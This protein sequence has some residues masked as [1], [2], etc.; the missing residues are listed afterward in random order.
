[1]NELRRKVEIKIG[2][3]EERDRLDQPM[4]AKPSVTS[5]ATYVGSV[6]LA[7]PLSL[8]ISPVGK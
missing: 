2:F 5:D 6:Y 4:A 8:I 3:C 1:M 7:E